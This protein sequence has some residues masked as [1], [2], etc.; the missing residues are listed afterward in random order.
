MVLSGVGPVC[1]QGKVP[2]AEVQRLMREMRRSMHTAGTTKPPV[3]NRFGFP[4]LPWWAWAVILLHM[5][6]RLYKVRVVQLAGGCRCMCMHWQG[7][8]LP[9]QLHKC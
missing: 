4:K 6:W 3:T 7:T 5:L 8:V 2:D 9:G 1:L